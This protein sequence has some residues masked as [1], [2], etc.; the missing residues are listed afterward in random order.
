MYFPKVSFSRACPRFAVLSL[1]ASLTLLSAC[2]GGRSSSDDDSDSGHL[3]ANVSP[4]TNG[5]WYR[6]PVN[7]T[8]TWQIQGKFNT[9]YDTDIYDIDLFDSAPELIDSLHRQGRKVICYFSAGTWE[10]GDPI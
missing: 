7:A 3:A 4:V 9:A 1:V 6:P 5:K 10:S 2:G 8:W